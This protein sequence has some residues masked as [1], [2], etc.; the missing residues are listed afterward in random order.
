[1]RSAAVVAAMV[2]AALGSTAGTVLAAP[3]STSPEFQFQ[4]TVVGQSVEVKVDAGALAIDD[5]HV[6][7]RDSRGATVASLPLAYRKDGATLPITAQLD[8]TKVTLTPATDPAAV[9]PV[10]AQ[11]RNELDQLAHPDGF[12]GSLG[13]FSQEVMTATAVGVLLGSAIGL[14][15]GCI[16]G[17]IVGGVTGGVVSIGVLALPGAIGGCLVTGAALAAIGAVVGTVAIGI[18]VLAAAAAQFWNS[19]H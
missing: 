4:G 1:M 19:T 9:R 16:G 7:F 13:T 14:A 2:V 3:A 11:T 8:G 12:A 5:G 6:L 10:N 18:P 15:V 17:G